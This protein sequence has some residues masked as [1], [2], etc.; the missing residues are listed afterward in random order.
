MRHSFSGQGVVHNRM[1]KI[2][3]GSSNV[4]LGDHDRKPPLRKLFKDEPH[5]LA[6]LHALMARSE[7]IKVTVK[8]TVKSTASTQW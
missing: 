5:Q 3:K 7:A 1:L 8:I 2:V 4:A 6:E